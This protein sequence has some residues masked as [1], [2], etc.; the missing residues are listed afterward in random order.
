MELSI[1]RSSY[2]MI[3]SLRIFFLQENNF[4]FIYDKCYRNGWA[5]SYLINVDGENIGYG[6]VWGKDKREDRD[7]IFE[8]YIIPTFRKFASF[9]FPRLQF[10]SEA[11]YIE[12]QTNDLLLSTMLY[13][14]AH[15][16]NAEAILFKDHHQT[17]MQIPGVIFTRHATTDEN[18]NDAGGFVL[19]MNGEVVASGGLML[20]YNMPYADIYM[21]VKENYRQKG[22]GSLIVQELKKE[23]YRMGRV[24]AAR[25]NIENKVSKATLLKAGFEV[26]GCRVVGSL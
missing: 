20:N 9:I 16:I 7:A 11:R 25:C 10:A 14:Y 6:S 23:A 13:E 8:F 4:Q 12:C 15:N 24:P 2:E 26:C 1:S 19:E 5:D 22:F 18:P 3:A 21:D 17:N